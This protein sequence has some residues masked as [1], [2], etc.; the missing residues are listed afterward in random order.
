MYIALLLCIFL[1][2]YRTIFSYEFLD[3]WQDFWTKDSVTIIHT[4]TYNTHTYIHIHTYLLYHING[5]LWKWKSLSRVQLFANSRGQNN[6][7]GSLSLLHGIFPTKGS[8]PGLL[9]YRQIL[10]QLNHKGSPR[11]LEWV[12]YPFS[13][14]PSQPRNQTR[15][16]CIVGGFFTNWAMKINL[17]LS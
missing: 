10:Y 8:N 5:S 13:R 3:N 16:S 11:I 17:S 2:C 7:V 4:H 9:H 6:R 15:V 1:V 12:A 14:G